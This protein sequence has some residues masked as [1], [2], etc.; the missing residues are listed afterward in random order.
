MANYAKTLGVT[1]QFMKL[2]ERAFSTV[3]NARFTA[4]IIAQEKLVAQ[5]ILIVSKSDHLDWAMPIF[6]QIKDIPKNVFKNAERLESFVEVGD[7]VK[8][9]ETY[10]KSHKSDRVKWRLDNLKKGIRGI[11]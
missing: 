5:R 1:E 4:Q 2:E 6:T 3:Q 11:D 7:S 8:Q 9:M 10:L